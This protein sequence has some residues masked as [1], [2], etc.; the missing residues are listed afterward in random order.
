MRMK[1]EFLILLRRIS[2]LGLSGRELMIV[3]FLYLFPKKFKAAT[4]GQLLRIPKKNLHR[5]LV[6]LEKMG[7]ISSTGERPLEYTLSSKLRQSH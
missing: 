6:G 3:V 5:V 4:I 1:E 7:I 2:P